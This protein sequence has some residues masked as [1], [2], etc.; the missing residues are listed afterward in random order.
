M[1]ITSFCQVSGF[2]SFHV[3]QCEPV[4][5]G[6]LTLSLSFNE[7]TFSPSDHERGWDSR[8]LGGGRRRFSDD[9]YRDI[10]QGGDMVQV[11][12]L[13]LEYGFVSDNLRGEGGSRSGMPRA[14][15]TLTS[16]GAQF[17]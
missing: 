9:N 11:Y 17:R 13:G 2:N 5:R 14:G 3:R 10:H 12:G 15:V 1:T 7:L 4:T 16:H 8:G 6:A